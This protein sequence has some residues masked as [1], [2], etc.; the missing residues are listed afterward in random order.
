MFYIK[1]LIHFGSTGPAVFLDLSVVSIALIY[2]Q[3]L[4]GI[5]CSVVV[6]LKNVI[7]SECRE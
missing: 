6:E 4:A 3:N 7:A 5:L 1:V 2:L